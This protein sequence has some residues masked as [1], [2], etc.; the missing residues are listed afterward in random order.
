MPAPR[1]ITSLSQEGAPG[2]Y[3]QELAP[4]VPTQG[5]RNRITG[6]AGQ[7]VRG[8]VGKAVYCPNYGRF[9]DVFG[10]RD[11]NSNGGTILGHVWKM[12]QGKRFGG[13]WVARVAAAAAVKASFTLETAAGGAGTQVVRVDAYGPGAAG[14]DIQFKVLAATDGQATHWNLSIKLYGRVYLYENLCT[15][16]VDNTNQV[17][18]SDD[19]VIIRLTKLA[20]GRPVNNAPSTDGAD[21][22]GYTNL[23]QVVANF[24]SVA[25]SD[26]AIADSDYTA[27][28]GPMEI[29]SN[30]RGINICLVAGRSN[31][32]IKTKIQALAAVASQRVWF[33]CPDNE[34]VTDT[35]AETERA[36]FT[37]TDRLSYW[38]NHPYI[39]DSVTNEEI[40]DEPHGLVASILSQTD[41]DVH[42]GDQRNAA[43]TKGVTR[44]YNELSDA[45]RDAL[46]AAGVSYLNADLDT[47]GNRII[48]PGNALTCDLNKNNRDLDQRYMKDFILYALALLMTGDLFRGNTPSARAARAGAATSFLTGLANAERYVLKDDQGNPMFSY[49]NDNTVNNL[50]DQGNGDQVDLLQCRLIA[51][52]KRILLNAFIGPTVVITETQNTSTAQG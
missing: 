48:I 3:V 43:Y 1:F 42:P 37:V 28:G 21:T 27:T 33:A 5:Q 51:K 15:T 8:P 13:V 18:G 17:I 35:S 10:E 9:R 47:S 26:G 4:P 20:D 41:P 12:F 39:I 14:N 52:N 24:T 34:T 40:V 11:R 46:D 16:G 6:I 38:F 25:G 31:A 7:C 2:V 22:N 32:T 30:T 49:K 23:G 44:V 45:Q 19:A 36:A 50:T 29:I